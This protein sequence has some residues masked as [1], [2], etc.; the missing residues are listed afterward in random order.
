MRLDK[1]VPRVGF[2]SNLCINKVVLDIGCF[3][4]TSINAKNNDEWLHGQIAIQSRYT[5]G[6][7]NSLKIPPEGICTSN[8]SKIYLGDAFDLP[9]HIDSS[10]IQIIVCGELI[11]HLENPLLFLRSLRQKYPG[12]TLVIS[13]PNGCSFANGLMGTFGMEVQHQDHLFNFTYKT[14]NTLFTKA[15]YNNFKILPYKFYASEMIYKSKGIKR[16]LARLVQAF[17][18][19]Y[20]YFFPLRSFGYIV[21]ANE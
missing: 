12:S 5:Y 19:F 13:T 15:G 21:I 3:D 2:I 9:G 14:L 20:E 1:P 7:D 4:E 6:V 18:R 10:S 11:E 17:I 16:N 8:K